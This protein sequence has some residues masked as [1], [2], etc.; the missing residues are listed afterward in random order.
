[1]S[2]QWVRPPR[3]WP[4]DSH[5]AGRRVTWLELFFDLVFVAALSQV[6]SPLSSDYS[7]GGVLRFLAFFL[8]IWWAWTGHTIYST[9]FDTDDLIQRGLTLV[10]MFAVA[11]MAANAKDA[12]DSRSS[13]G[14]GAAYAAM[15]LILVLQYLRARRVPES[16]QLTTHYA[17]GFGLAAVVWVISAFAPPPERYWMWGL[18]LAIDLGTPFLAA[19]HAERIPPDAVHLP[20]R[21]GLFTIILL[22]ESVVAVM[23]GMESQETWSLPAALSAFQGMAITFCLWWWYFDGA[24]GSAARPIRSRRHH[25]LFH[26]WSY[27]HLPLYLGIVLVAVGI[28]H[29]VALAPGAHLHASEAWILCAAAALA[30][31]SLIAIAAT[32]ET[33]Q[34]RGLL[35]QVL[36]AGMAL[37]L[38]LPGRQLPPVILVSTLTGLCVA[39][40][41]L[42]MRAPNEN[43]K[44]EAGS[45][46]LAPGFGSRQETTMHSGTQN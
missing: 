42:S 20:E 7:L 45:G 12:F 29:I 27:A 3:L 6:D 19:H 36:L 37:L 30:M 38:G 33:A 13:A 26:L 43:L 24:A 41:A 35:P 17:L 8:L 2:I 1:M 11:A 10:Q 31:L 22:G 46:E 34:Q 32:S 28:K 4:P 44:I 16:R 15:R 23:H 25:V 18:A 40:A 9:R 39:Q 21:F 14:F 5:T